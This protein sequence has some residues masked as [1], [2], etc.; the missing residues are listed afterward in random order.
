MTVIK[1]ASLAGVSERPTGI[2]ELDQRIP[3]LLSQLGAYVADDAKRRLAPLGV[4]PRVN[5]I[6]FALAGTDG[7][8]QRQLSARLGVHRNVMVS[9]I[10][11]LEQQGL[12]QRRPH[13]DDR[14]A[15]A[16]TLTDKA[17]DLLP[18]LEEQSDA[19][20]DD[21]TAA[22]SAEE[23]AALLGMLQRVAAALGLSPG[24]HPKLAETAPLNSPA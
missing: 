4:H 8:S 13:P 9:L 7:Q 20:E 5:A 18:A 22:L 2:A 19:I 24:V 15:F 10:D 23:R 17:R 21:V 11:S 14:R 3:F 12:V 1:S 6:L 16:V